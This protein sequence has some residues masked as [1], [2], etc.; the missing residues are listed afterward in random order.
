MGHIC[1]SS[2]L[3]INYFRTFQLLV[4][5]H[6]LFPL[7]SSSTFLGHTAIHILQEYFNTVLYHCQ[8]L[9]AKMFLEHPQC[10]YYFLLLSFYSSSSEGLPLIFNAKYK[11]YFNELHNCIPF[12]TS[13]ASKSSIVIY[14]VS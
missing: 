9:H 3:L 13:I 10:M 6:E 12:L 5:V 4:L 2:L 11:I 1:F 7:I 14:L 8:I